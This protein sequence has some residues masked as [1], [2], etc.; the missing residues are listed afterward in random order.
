MRRHFFA[1]LLDGSGY[2]KRNVKGPA[3]THTESVCEGY[4]TNPTIT[5]S[6]QQC[7]ISNTKKTEQSIV[8]FFF[9]E[10]GQRH[11]HNTAA[12]LWTHNIYYQTDAF[13]IVPK[14][15]RGWAAPM[16]SVHS[17]LLLH[18]T[19]RVRRLATPRNWVQ[20]P[21]KPRGGV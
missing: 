8:Q 21:T 13:C 5:V 17:C 9:C 2:K 3:I 10:G 18:M 20:A 7:K 15:R 4:K 14:K 6:C 19:M 11:H 16:R 12:P 1:L